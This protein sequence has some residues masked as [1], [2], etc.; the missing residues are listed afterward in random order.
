MFFNLAEIGHPVLT[1]P[2]FWCLASCT[3]LSKERQRCLGT[4]DV[5]ARQTVGQKHRI[6]CA[7][8]SVKPKHTVILAPL[9]LQLLPATR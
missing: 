2:A 6:A 7:A 9:P 8:L 3:E 4:E 5:C 1:R